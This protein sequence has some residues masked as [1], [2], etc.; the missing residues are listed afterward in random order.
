MTPLPDRTVILG[1]LLAVGLCFALA[2]WT[3]RI[4]PPPDP[5]LQWRSPEALPAAPERGRGALI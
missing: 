5:P 4:A 1:L 2:A 3:A